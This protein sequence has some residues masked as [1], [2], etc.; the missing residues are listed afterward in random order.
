MLWHD[1]ATT[2]VTFDDDLNDGV[3]RRMEDITSSADYPAA[4]LSGSSMKVHIEY[5]DFNV[6]S[7]N[8]SIIYHFLI[9]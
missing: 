8:R 3:L 5:S 6:C 7:R 4:P 9:F 1:N 2:E